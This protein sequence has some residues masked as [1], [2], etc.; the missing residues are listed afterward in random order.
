[1][2]IGTSVRRLVRQR[3]SE[4]CEYYGLAQ[5]SFPLVTFHVE[6]VIAKQHGGSDDLDNLCLPC[7][8]CNLFKGPNLSTMVD[9]ELKRLFHPRTDRWADHFAI[10]EGEIRGL[11]AIG[12]ATVSLLN[13]NDP[14]R[15]EL[16]RWTPEQ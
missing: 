12:N 3:A 8:W 6:H 11:T 4:K 7:H 5:S 13:M 16:R 1:M 10:E 14:D 15:V 2:T 9:G